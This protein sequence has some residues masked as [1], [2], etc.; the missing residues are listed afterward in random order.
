[1]RGAMA[2]LIG[3]VT[4]RSWTQLGLVTYVPFLYVDV[5]GQDPRVVGLLLFLFLGAGAVG[6]LAGGPIADRWGSRRYL[7]ASFLLSIPL[8]VLFLWRPGGWL[9]AVALAATG[10]VLVSSF[11]I[12]VALGQA[13]CRRASGW[14]PDSSWDWPS[15]PGASA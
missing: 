13:S 7:V 14:P 2:L 11:S 8:I 3:V 15:A 10:F 1:M 12:T 5:L 6:T 9:A 4:V